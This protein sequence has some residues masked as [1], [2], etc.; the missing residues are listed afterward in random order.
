MSGRGSSTSRSLG[1]TTG[2]RAAAFRSSA[3]SRTC[4]SW[5]EVGFV[6]PTSDENLQ[7]KRWSP[8]V[9]ESCWQRGRGQ[10]V[11]LLFQRGSR[12]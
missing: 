7:D 2:F 6:L 1:S 11:S 3:R 4:L 5:R 12:A 8:R 9:S 10:K